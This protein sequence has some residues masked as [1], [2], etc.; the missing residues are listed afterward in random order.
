MPQPESRTEHE[1]FK[2]SH[3]SNGQSKSNGQGG[4]EGRVAF[5]AQVAGDITALLRT[6]AET[7]TDAT[8]P[9][10]LYNALANKLVSEH[11]SPN[12]Q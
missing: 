3:D 9:T 11:L 1:S 12:H 7:T 10:L 6:E 5:T 2:H 4:S 8:T